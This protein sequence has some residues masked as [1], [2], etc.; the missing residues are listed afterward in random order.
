[1]ICATKNNSK[2][3][4][5]QFG[6][7]LI[8]CLAVFALLALV[9]SHVSAQQNATLS[10]DYAGTLG[11]LHIRLHLKQTAAGKVTGTLDSIDRGAMGIRCEDFHVDGQAVTFSVPAVQGMWT[12]TLAPDGTLNGTWV[13]GHSLPLNFTRDAVQERTL[14]AS[15]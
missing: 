1:M 11:P 6:I 5:I 14:T 10:G 3:F 12:G 13:Q 9:P 7:G 4:A 2:R 15:R 8:A